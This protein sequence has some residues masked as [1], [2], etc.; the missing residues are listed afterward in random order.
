V[1]LRWLRRE[2]ERLRFPDETH[3]LCRSGPPR[4]RIMCAELILDWSASI[5]VTAA[6]PS[7]E[8][9]IGR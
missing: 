1:A 4:H 6:G 3:E 2:P 9:A 7:R 5:C 8:P